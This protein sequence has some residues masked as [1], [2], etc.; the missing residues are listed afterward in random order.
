[1]IQTTRVSTVGGFRYGRG[2]QTMLNME[3]SL[4]YLFCGM[5][6]SNLLRCVFALGRLFADVVSFEAL[7][8]CC[9][10]LGFDQLYFVEIAGQR[11]PGTKIE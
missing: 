9:W 5:A 1:M 10:Y 7:D 11:L 6:L 2:I 3:R 4:V 8:L